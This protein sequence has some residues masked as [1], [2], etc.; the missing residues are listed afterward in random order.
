MLSLGNDSMDKPT[1]ERKLHFSPDGRTEIAVATNAGA[2]F[3]VVRAIK[4]AET[5]VEV[6]QKNK[7]P[8]FSFGE[9]IHNPMVV[10]GLQEKGVKAV[11]EAREIESGLVVLRSHGV[12]KSYEEE[13]RKRGIK[14]FDATCPLVKKPQRLAKGVGEKGFFLVIVGNSDH[15]E[16]KG[17]L[18]YFGSDAYL[19]TYD[20]N[21]V[22]KIPPD[23]K[24]VGI[25]AQTTIEVRVFEEIVERCRHRFED[26]SAYNT[27]CDATSIRQ[28]E[29]DELAKQAEV[30]V[31]VGGKN[32]S[33]TAKLV[34]ICKSHGTITHLIEEL[35]EIDV[36]WFSGKR[37]IGVTGGASTPVEYVDTVGEHI[38]HLIQG[39]GLRVCASL[40]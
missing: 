20:P 38:S 26:V 10:R 25:I 4:L 16:V 17:V 24:G 40:A 32:S 3:G 22:D 14:V 11:E 33:N 9:L 21:D 18:S 35:H 7:A 27:I 37:K 30:M 2:C 39:Q 23:V 29:V 13:L 19:V 8:V 12:K 5:A 15:P 34:K 6:S 36:S 31:V 28:S 1:V